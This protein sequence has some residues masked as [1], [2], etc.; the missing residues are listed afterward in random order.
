M[1]SILFH[2]PRISSIAGGGETVT[3]QLITLLSQVGHEITI[4]TCRRAART[5]LLEH[6]LS[7]NPRLKIEELPVSEANCD[8]CD[9]HAKAIW[10][11]DRLAPESL[12]FNM[13]ARSFYQSRSFDL[14]VISFILDLV[15]LASCDP[16]LLNVFGLPPNRDIA[17]L[18]RPL[19]SRCS[20]FT[21][22]SRFVREEFS[23]L[24]EMADGVPL[25]PVVHSSI[26]P[27]FYSP[28]TSDAKKIEV[29]YA[30]R[31]VRRKGLDVV[32]NALAWL[33]EHR[34]RRVRM[35]V[36]GDGPERQSLQALAADI[37]IAEQVDWLGVMST[38]QVV[39]LLDSSSV[40]V[41]P[42]VRPEAFGCS[43][44]EAMARGM[45]VITT[46]IGGTADYVEPCENALVCEPGD[47]LGLAECI[48]TA[49]QGEDLRV[50]LAHKARATA[51]RFTPEAQAAKWLSVFQEALKKRP[52]A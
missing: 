38:D 40:F 25:G 44:V 35:A 30:G 17:Q 46:N 14:V 34:G 6:A 16:V 7:S 3:L 51:R 41:Y 21:F 31:L 19:L 23:T 1:A 29:C 47:I 52:P 27:E 18:E 22:A 4:L 39:E 13:A 2:D 11:S 33:K 5:R 10:H 26:Q 9:N 43:N 48:E 15:G 37:G 49:L 20:H 50:R 24:F 12:A 8:D 42:T 28:P 45:T 32:L 36:A